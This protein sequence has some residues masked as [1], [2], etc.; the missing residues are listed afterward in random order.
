MLKKYIEQLSETDEE[1]DVIFDTLWQN[2]ITDICE[3]E[4]DDILAI[5]RL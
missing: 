1:E 3:K 5:W 2:Q 4:P